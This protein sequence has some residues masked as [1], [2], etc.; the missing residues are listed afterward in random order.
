MLSCSSLI[1]YEKILAT[2]RNPVIS[3]RHT[4]F[5]LGMK[6]NSIS[7]V[8]HLKDIQFKEKKTTLRLLLFDSATQFTSM[9]G[10]IQKTHEGPKASDLFLTMQV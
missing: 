9:K 2:S 4:D 8:I 3:F 5:Y 10:A 7:T 6:H 1:S